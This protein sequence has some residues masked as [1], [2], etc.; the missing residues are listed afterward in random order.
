MSCSQAA[1]RST[2]WSSGMRTS[3]TWSPRFTTPWTC[4]QRSSSARSRSSASLR[5][6]RA[7]V[8]VARDT[9]TRY[10][11]AGH[12]RHRV[13]AISASLGHARSDHATCREAGCRKDRA[14]ERAVIR[15][16]NVVVFIAGTGRS[17]PP[18]CSVGASQGCGSDTSRDTATMLWG[19]CTRRPEPHVGE[20]L[21]RLAA[22]SSA[23]GPTCGIERRSASRSM[24][25]NGSCVSRGGRNRHARLAR[26][27]GLVTVT[28]LRHPL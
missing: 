25:R 8:V 9:I 18:V 23:L 12:R 26:L 22:R 7:A 13:R 5:A 24:R 2:S 16:Q 4:R 19:P 14:P 1:A 28:K 17:P 20:Q 27:R 6:L 3:A 15:Q 10:R 21:A 11:P